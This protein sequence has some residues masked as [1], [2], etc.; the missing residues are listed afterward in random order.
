MTVPTSTTS[1]NNATALT[2]EQ[3]E[4]AR[5][6][7]EELHAKY[8]YLGF[9]LETDKPMRELWQDIGVLHDR[10]D[11]IMIESNN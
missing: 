2:A 1:E 10:L 3:I 8:A 6:L 9:V 7:V 11:G 4:N 5:L